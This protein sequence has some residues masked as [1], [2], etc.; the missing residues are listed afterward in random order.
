MQTTEVVRAVGRASLAWMFLKAG[1]NVFRDPTRATGTAGP[2][3]G[4]VRERLPVPMPA[5]R[6]VVRINAATQVVTSA[7]ILLNVRPRLAAAVLSGSM[8][9]TTLAGHA[10]WTQ[11]DPG[12][13]RTHQMQFDKNLAMIGGL[14]LL[15]AGPRRERSR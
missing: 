7:L 12:V 11:D 2:L 9:P 10:Y 14:L 1:T 15:V 5:D 3:L 4:S 6:D 13:R 8:V